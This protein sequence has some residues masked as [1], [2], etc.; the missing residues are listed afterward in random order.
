MMNTFLALVH[1][2][3]N[4]MAVSGFWFHHKMAVAYGYTDS[5]VYR[6]VG[7]LQTRNWPYWGAWPYLAQVP[8]YISNFSPP[9]FKKISESRL[10]NKTIWSGSCIS[11]PAV[12]FFRNIS[13]P[14]LS[15]NLVGGEILWAESL[16][17]IRTSRKV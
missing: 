12:V 10:W 15:S 11:K 6:C 7:L 16:K 9:N 8:Y 3:T 2:T 4:K 17:V 14:F 1:H 5:F 13:L